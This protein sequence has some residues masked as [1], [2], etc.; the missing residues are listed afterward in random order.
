[1]R[2]NKNLVQQGA[3]SLQRTAVVRTTIPALIEESLGI[4]VDGL[5]PVAS[6]RNVPVLN[7]AELGTTLASDRGSNNK[8]LILG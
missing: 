6:S 5:V 3:G 4:D 8:T 2:R 1:M 7:R